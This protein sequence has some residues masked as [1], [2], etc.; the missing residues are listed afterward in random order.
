MNR[1][2]LVIMMLA[3][4]MPAVGAQG[5]LQGKVEQ[6]QGLQRLNRPALPSKPLGDSMEQASSPSKQKSSF[7]MT[8]STVGS[9]LDKGAFDF[10]NRAAAPAAVRGGIEDSAPKNE[11]AD[12]EMVIAWERWHKHLSEIIYHYWL[13]YSTVPGEGNVTLTISKDGDISFTLAGFQIP[14]GEQI[15][16]DQRHQEQMFDGCLTHT[17]NMVS[18]TDDIAFPSGSQRKSVTL[19][20]NFKHSL[21]ENTHQGYDWKR[22]D[23]ERVNSR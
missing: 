11:S 9:A 18:H 12:K 20:C 4:C 15:V 7:Q 23:Y 6:R 1:S 13:N 14:T 16:P 2:L 3:T 21:A 10:S 5:P 22:G 17:L 8:A 19:T